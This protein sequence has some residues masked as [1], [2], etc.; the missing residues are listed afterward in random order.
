[1]TISTVSS[2]LTSNC[3]VPLAAR[4]R[5]PL[6]METFCSKRILVF[7]ELLYSKALY[8]IT[9][10]AKSSCRFNS[11]LNHTQLKHLM[12]LLVYLFL[13]LVIV[14]SHLMSCL[15]I[16]PINKNLCLCL[17]LVL[18]KSLLISTKKTLNSL[19]SYKKSPLML[20]LIH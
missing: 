16:V 9:R 6:Y 11:H 14:V 8:L 4:N 7:V 3:Y 2:S 20:H 13:A 1:M 15:P 17:K 12:V 19:D 18:F 5:M 10:E